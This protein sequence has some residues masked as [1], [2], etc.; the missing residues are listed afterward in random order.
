MLKKTTRAFL[1]HAVRWWYADLTAIQRDASVT[2]F[3]W[4]HCFWRTLRGFRSAVIRWAFDIRRHYIKREYT[5]LVEQVGE[6]TRLKY[7]KLVTVL[8]CGH[9][10][11]ASEF[12]HAVT[13]AETAA[14]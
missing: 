12:Q 10:Q 11:L 13:Q 4:Q 3:N 8:P 2:M 5:H 14:S 9:W 6:V 7:S 1:R